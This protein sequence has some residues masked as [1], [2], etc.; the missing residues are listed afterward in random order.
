MKDS[1]SL[2]EEEIDILILDYLDRREKQSPTLFKYLI[3]WGANATDIRKYITTPELTKTWGDRYLYE[4]DEACRLIVERNIIAPIKLPQ[5]TVE[6]TV[7]A[8]V[9]MNAIMAFSSYPYFT[10]EVSR[11]HV[12]YYLE[13]NNIIHSWN[14]DFLIAVKKKADEAKSFLLK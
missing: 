1:L 7:I 2:K 14:T 11:E 12:I 6:D 9:I 3:L 10:G 5:Q 4:L 8:K 13:R